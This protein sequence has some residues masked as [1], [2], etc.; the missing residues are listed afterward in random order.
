MRTDFRKLESNKSFFD[1]ARYTRLAEDRG[2]IIR[3]RQ[4]QEM[5]KS[6]MLQ[7]PIEHLLYDMDFID[8]Y[9][10]ISTKFS[11]KDSAYNYQ[12]SQVMEI[13]ERLGVHTKLSNGDQFF[14]DYEV[15]NDFKFRFGLTI[16][17]NIVDFDST[18]INDNLNI[19]SGGFWGL[20][21][22]LMTN[23]TITVVKPGFSNIE[24]LTSLLEEAVKLH[25]DVKKVVMKLG[26]A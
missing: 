18:I 13:L 19:K 2:I 11:K 22:Q 23:W 3:F 26:S 7:L 16:K 21:V 6:D 8:R 24:Q 25:N 4:E 10:A 9:K 15:I 5:Q 1:I 17:Y 12:S 14:S 20:I